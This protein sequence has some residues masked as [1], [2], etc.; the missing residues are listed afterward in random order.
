MSTITVPI[1][2]E[3]ENFIEEEISLGVSETKAGLVRHALSRLQEERALSRLQEAEMDIQ[4][5]RV[6][7]GDLKTLLKKMK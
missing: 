7:K 6:Y 3:L 1:S 5:G 4:Q 2:K